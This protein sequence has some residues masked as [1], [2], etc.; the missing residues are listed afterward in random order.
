MD[1]SKSYQSQ[2]M[3]KTENNLESQAIT[4]SSPK[5][6]TILVEKHVIKEYVFKFFFKIIFHFSI[7]EHLM[8]RLSALF[9]DHYKNKG[10]LPGGCF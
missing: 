1:L 9:S 5:K 7:W 4:K 10:L 3:L 2:C 6:C 8:Q